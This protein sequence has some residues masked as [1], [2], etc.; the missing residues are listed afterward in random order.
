MINGEDSR[1]EM[2]YH[3]GLSDRENFRKNYLQPTLAEGLIEMT[4]PEKPQS[5]KQR[6]R[7][8]S[9]GVNARKI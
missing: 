8:T 9:R 6:Y 7:L 4:I 3:L 5:S 2:Q 1:S